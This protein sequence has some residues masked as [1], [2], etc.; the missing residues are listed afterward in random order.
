MRITKLLFTL[1]VFCLSLSGAAVA[2]AETV[3][4]VGMFP[5]ITH[6]QALVAR[7]M[8]AQGRCWYAQRLP[9]VRI[10]WMSFNAGPS[11]MEALFAKALDFTYVGPNP[12]LNAF[13]RSK[14]KDVRVLSGAV[15]G[16]AA[17]VV[18]PGSNLSRPIDFKGKRIG[19]PQL[20]NTQDI[21][22]RA[23]LTEGGL[24]VRFTGGDV[25]VLPT[26][27]P[28]QLNLFMSKHLDGVWTVEPWVSRLELEAGGVVVYSEPAALSITTVLVGRAA[29]IEEQPQAA[30]A[31]VR[32]HEE[33]TRW[34]VEHPAEA[35]AA[36]MAELSRIT[37]RPFPA[38]LVEKAWPRLTF[39]TAI[40]Q[41]D[42]EHALSLSQAAG[43]SKDV[44]SID[45]LVTTS[46]P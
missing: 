4:R 39:S 6:A 21:A 15:R 26:A 22:C 37:R 32:A 1:T 38:E 2:S 23:W 8:A 24:N 28:D 45:G 17:L 3:L 27:N 5:N 13:A 9:G 34:I 36:V 20:G 12:A 33:L 42:F 14:G 11:A 40:S 30:A 44:G 7:N 35:Q 31:F 43:F 41:G 10:E 25:Q 16:G 29:F 18:Q 46:H 19:T